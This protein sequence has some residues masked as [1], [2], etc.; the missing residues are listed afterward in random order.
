[1]KEFK[2]S[3]QKV[4]VMIITYNQQDFIAKTIDSV[5]SQDYEN[6]EIVIADDAS[7]DGT[8]KILKTYEEK[9]SNIKLVLNPKNLGI[10]GNSNAALLACTGDLIAVMGGDD[11]FLDGKI[12]AQVKEFSKNSNLVLSYHPV[13]IFDSKT[14]KAIFLTNQR[15]REDT[16]SAIDIIR[17]LGAGGPSSIM[18]RKSACPIHGFDPAIP[19]AS[20]WIFTI[21]VATKGEVQKLNH[22]YSRYRK[23]DNNIGHQLHKYFHEFFDTL[24]I[25]SKRYKN[26]PSMQ[27][28]CIFARAR[29]H[30]G[31]A[32]RKLSTDR[33]SAK[34]HFLLAMHAQPYDI[35]NYF[36]Y[37][38]AK[39]RF[40]A[41]LIV[42]FKYAIKRLI[43]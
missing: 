27:S 1:M 22:V 21:E 14:N 9:F 2:Q 17:K 29:L 31:E 34:K 19:T 18:V 23:H 3:S 37:L 10:T 33:E 8:I 32:F 6:L 30:A 35:K 41:L 24:D 13:E 38:I 39:S 4:S 28:A 11:L 25:V 36:G 43:G 7:T 26:I 15:Q 42:K 5:L 20:D 16:N 12:S 40:I